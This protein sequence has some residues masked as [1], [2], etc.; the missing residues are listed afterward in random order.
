MQCWRAGEPSAPRSHEWAVEC[1]SGLSPACALQPVLSTSGNRDDPLGSPMP[2]RNPFELAAA[3][4]AVQHW[5][6]HWH[7]NSTSTLLTSSVAV[8][9]VSL[10]GIEAA[11]EWSSM[12]FE[13]S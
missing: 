4:A 6:V 1:A 5:L 10:S 3:A 7:K 12:P 13:E 11:V 2:L 9:W 8:V